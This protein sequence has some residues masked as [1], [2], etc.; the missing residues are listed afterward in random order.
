MAAGARVTVVAPDTVTAIDAN[1]SLRIERRAYR[2]GEASEYFL[3][4][5]A[6]GAPDVDRAVVAD[7]TA[8][9]VLVNS[10][11]QATPGSVRLPAVHRD[12]PV[13][14]AVSTGGASPALAAWV[15]HRVAS[16]VPG[17]VGTIADLLEDARRA[18]KAKGRPTESV[19]WDRLLD[20]QVVP[21][22]ESGRID[23]ARELLE[24]L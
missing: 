24:R 20:E 21:L 16:A 22:V 11:D 6:T 13:T 17:Q 3:V 4:L 5:T 9:G 10:A 14:V 1:R 8:A 12:G 19:D 7:A 2:R 15:R 23:E 18:L